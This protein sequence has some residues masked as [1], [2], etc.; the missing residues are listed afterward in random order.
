MIAD[1]KYELVPI[2]K[3]E[4]H[5]DNPRRGDTGAI[6]ESIEH[7]GFYGAVIAQKSTGRILAGNHRW[8]AAKTQ[9]E[10]KVPVL[11]IDVDDDRARKILLADNKTNDLATY[12]E[13]ALLA[14]LDD[15]G[16]DA[17]ALAGTA[18]SVDDLEDL[19]VR[20]GEVPTS[21]PAPIHPDYAESEEEEH[22]RTANLGA[23]TGSAS[24]LRD[25]VVV[26]PLDEHAAAVE[27][28]SELRE[29]ADAEASS[30]E[31]VLAALR[32]A[33]PEAMRAHLHLRDAA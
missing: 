28:I 21:E 3:L 2:G 13:K 26:L 15:V 12:D 27:R 11:W 17:S 22:E 24:G 16:A 4:P 19:A 8:K 20:V 7:N 5:P 32:A 31:I 14:L 1:Q 25:L 30:G 10:K 33:E 29:A 9:G 23:N 18:Y 6:A